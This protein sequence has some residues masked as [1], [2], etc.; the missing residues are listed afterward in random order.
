[1]EAFK[2][3]NS[4]NQLDLFFLQKTIARLRKH[5]GCYI[6]ITFLKNLEDVCKDLLFAI[7]NTAQ[8]FF[9]S[10]HPKHKKIS[11]NIV[12]CHLQYIEERLQELATEPRSQ[13]NSMTCCMLTELYTV[14]CTMAL[15]I[16]YSFI[17]S[18]F[19]D[20]IDDKDVTKCATRHIADTHTFANRIFN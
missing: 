17:V 12:D 18:A 1:M 7:Q 6:S 20:G 11:D 15:Q 3:Q 10:P 8:G 4:C 2:I 14:L 5:K 13:K 9:T 19:D 16:R